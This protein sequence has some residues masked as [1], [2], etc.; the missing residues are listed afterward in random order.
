LVDLDLEKVSVVLPLLWDIRDLDVMLDGMLELS[1]FL[2][3]HSTLNR[4]LEVFGLS[5]DILGLFVVEGSFPAT[6]ICLSPFG[7][8][9]SLISVSNIIDLFGKSIHLLIWEVDALIGLHKV[10]LKDLSDISPLLDHFL[11]E[12]RLDEM[13]IDFLKVVDLFGMSPLLKC[14]LK[15]VDWHGVLDLLRDPFNILS[16]SLDSLL[17]LRR[18]F[19]LKS[20]DGIMDRIGRD[21]TKEKC[22]GKVLHI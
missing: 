3:E 9:E 14:V 11:S 16:L 1:H 17:T 12:W 7:L 5:M 13:S 4:L 8:E 20:V 18:D 15:F 21:D 22:D 6:L 10:I 19:D 2:L